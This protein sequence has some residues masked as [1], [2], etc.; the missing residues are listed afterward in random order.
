[1]EYSTDIN[2]NNINVQTS[3]ELNRNNADNY[4]ILQIEDGMAQLQFSM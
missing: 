4:N 1:M 2:L 3:F